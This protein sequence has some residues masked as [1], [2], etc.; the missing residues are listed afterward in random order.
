MTRIFAILVL[1]HI[2]EHNLIYST[3]Q[4]CF[5][6]LNRPH[7]DKIPQQDD[8]QYHVVTK[9]TT[10]QTS[11]K[12]RQYKKKKNLNLHGRT[13]LLSNKIKVHN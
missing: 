3:D 2:N 6:C 7:T 8:E 12:G 10:N 11:I 5:V 13:Y 1:Q 9:P 4:I